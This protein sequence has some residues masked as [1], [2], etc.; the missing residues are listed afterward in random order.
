MYWMNGP[1]YMKEKHLTQNC[2]YI[3]GCWWTEIL[4]F[5]GTLLYTQL[6]SVT[7]KKPK[8]NA[9]VFIVVVSVNHF[10][11]RRVKQIISSCWHITESIQNHINAETFP[12]KD[13]PLL[14]SYHLIQITTA[15]WRHSC[16]CPYHTHRTQWYVTKMWAIP[17]KEDVNGGV[18]SCMKTTLRKSKWISGWH[19]TVQDSRLWPQ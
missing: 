8:K 5:T 12:Y 9:A 11:L 7:V 10:Y 18:E 2:W 15:A 14:S 16:K 17:H 1:T 3:L 6:L 19:F 4:S 13:I